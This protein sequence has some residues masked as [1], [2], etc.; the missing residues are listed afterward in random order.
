MERL[1]ELRMLSILHK[2][3]ARRISTAKK[4]AGLFAW[5]TFDGAGHV[6]KIRKDAFV[7][8]F[9]ADV[10]RELGEEQQQKVA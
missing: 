6:W 9:E 10:A 5:F 1:T 3:G 7:Q 2:A 8:N 4:F